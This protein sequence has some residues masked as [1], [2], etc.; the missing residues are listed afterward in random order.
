MCGDCHANEVMMSKYDISTN[1]F[2]SYVADFHGTTATIFAHENPNEPINTAVCYD[3]HG[4]HDIQSI[5]DATE[6]QIQERLL[7]TCRA[8][9]PDAS[10]NFPAS[11]MSH[12]EPS[13]E[14]YPA[15]YL[16]DLFYKVLIPT[17]M[18]GFLL[19]IGS[20]IFRRFTDRWVARR[21]RRR[22]DG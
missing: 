7:E 4:V 17:V 19:F 13:L 8:C 22:G 3:C 11:W 14:N 1:V 10:E 21:K 5:S 18:G 15:V 16:V 9:H 2:D 6:Q 20:D 12:Y